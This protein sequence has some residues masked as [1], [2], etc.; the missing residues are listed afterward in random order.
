MLPIKEIEDIAKSIKDVS[1]T[2]DYNHFHRVA[3]GARWFVKILSGTRREEELAYVAGLLHDCVRPKTEKVCHANVS[4]LKSR[5]I[6]EGLGVEKEVIGPVVEAIQDH[7]KPVSWKSPLHQSVY[8][9]DKI[10]EQM[11]HYV[12]FRR[13]I[14][15]GE[16]SDYVGKPFASSISYH[17]EYRINKFTKDAFPE[18]FHQLV[19]GRLKPVLDFHRL[20]KEGKEWA[21]ALARHCYDEGR[22]GENPMDEIIRTFKPDCKEAQDYKNQAIQYIDG[23]VFKD[24]EDLLGE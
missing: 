15:V 9:A 22:F 18:R 19:S 24:L 12:T 6:L 11:G 1:I 4:A 16:C 8:L 21:I 20:F 7:R 23:K 5:G 3:T 13:C 17:F 10:L 14:Y 2:H